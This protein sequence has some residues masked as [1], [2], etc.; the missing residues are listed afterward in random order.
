MNHYSS[1]SSDI[2]GPNIKDYIRKIEVDTE[3]I[4]L[5]LNVVPNDIMHRIG[6][7]KNAYDLHTRL[8]KLHENLLRLDDK[9]RED[10]IEDQVEQES[11]MLGLKGES[12]IEG[13]KNINL[14]C[15]FKNHIIYFKCKKRKYYKYKCLTLKNNL[16][17]SM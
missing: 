17:Q 3:V 13:S 14:N 16:A 5:L 7:F 10:Q 4:N 8:I 2:N 1:P 11:T 15:N 9:L 6:R 12:P